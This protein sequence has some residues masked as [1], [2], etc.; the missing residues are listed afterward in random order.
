MKQSQEVEL[1]ELSKVIHD[2]AVRVRRIEEA[3]LGGLPP[4]GPTSPGPGPTG[5]PKLSEVND[6]IEVLAD[7]ISELLSNIVNHDE[8]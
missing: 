5:G 4:G 2:I 1:E 3:L 8:I 6:K 7:R